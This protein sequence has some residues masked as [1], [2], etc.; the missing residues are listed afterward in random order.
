MRQTKR[1]FVMF[2]FYDR[3]GIREYLERQAAQGWMLEKTS[4]LGWV[5]RRIE[6]QRVHFAVTYFPQASVFDPEPSEE[7]QL[8]RDFCAH[9]GWRLVAA[10]AQ[11]QIFCNEGADPVPIETDA[12]LE[13][14]TIHKAMKKFFLPNYLLMLLTDMLVLALWVWRLGQDPIGVLSRGLLYHVGKSA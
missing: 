8:F 2:S 12:V 11:M 14:E 5:F 4:A 10:N 13:V 1:T 7:Q 9:T 6:P 3:T